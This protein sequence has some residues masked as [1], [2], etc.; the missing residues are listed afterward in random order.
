MTLR[1]QD[2]NP[3]ILFRVGYLYADL[4]T[5]GECPTRSGNEGESIKPARSFDRR[6]S[7]DG[8]PRRL[9]FGANIIIAGRAAV[10]RASLALLSASP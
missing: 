3:P 10:M 5:V 8:L 9:N 6:R 2:V 7:V 1:T 4:I